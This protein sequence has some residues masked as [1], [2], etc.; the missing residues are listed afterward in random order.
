MLGFCKT[1]AHMAGEVYRFDNSVVFWNC[2]RAMLDVLLALDTPS[3]AV[4]RLAHGLLVY[5]ATLEGDGMM[6]KHRTR[7][8]D[9][10]TT[11]DNAAARACPWYRQAT[12]PRAAICP[13]G[14]WCHKQVDD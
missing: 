5:P 1:A 8:Q 2:T 9:K 13:N 3:R 6:A 12:C 11:A 14:A 4:L 7:G 10:A